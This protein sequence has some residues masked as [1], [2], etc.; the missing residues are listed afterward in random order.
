L[1][2]DD[3]LGVE[4]LARQAVALESTT[5]SQA[6]LALCNRT[7]IDAAGRVLLKRRMP[8]K[9]GLVSGLE[10]I[11]RSVQWG[12]NV[13]GE[14]AVGLFRREVLAKDVRFDPGNPYLIDLSFWADLIRHGDAYIEAD[15]LAAFRVS[16]AAVSTKIGYRQAALFR[17]FVRKLRQDPFYRISRL[18]LLTG[19]VF[20]LPWC[21]LRNL[22]LHLHTQRRCRELT[23]ETEG[24]PGRR[25]AC[26]RLPKSQ[27]IC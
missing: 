22:F 18:D 3:L 11:R 26:G 10:L 27:V 24:P 17:C 2:G 14:P 21:F 12:S 15:F 6:V 1:C 23:S 9:P 13:V 4:C 8:F 19:Y 16:G 20:S 5:N 7:V 25:P